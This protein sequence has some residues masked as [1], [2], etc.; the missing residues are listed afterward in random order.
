[1]APQ[2]FPGILTSLGAIREWVSRAAADAGVAGAAV[3]DL[4]LAVDE[5]ATNTITHGYK[6]DGGELRLEAA[7]ESGR[8]TIR[9]DDD[10]PPFDPL[11]FAGPTKAVLESGLQERAPG[12]LGIMLARRGVDEL[13]HLR[14]ERGNAYLFILRL[15]K[16]AAR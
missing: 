10:A 12:G 11:L 7:V 13:R 5:I 3:Y 16:G 2:T 6:K 15:H 4:C 14:T 9:M 8:F 1:M